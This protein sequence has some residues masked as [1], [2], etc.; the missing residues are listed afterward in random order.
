MSANQAAIAIDARPTVSNPLDVIPNEMPFDVPYGWPISLDRAQ[1]VIQAAVAEAKKREWKMN[2]AVVDS[3]GNLVA[4]QRMDGAM[5]ASIQI[6]EH[7]ARA[8]VTF[9]RPT[10][11]FEDGINLMHLNYLL[12]F[13]GVI[14]SRGGI[15]LIDQGVIIGA[16]GCS[17]GTDSQDEV[18]S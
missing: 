8:A 3:G 6:A 4:F 5:L 12:A 10:K 15:P 16:I 9:R 1:A 14:A 18:V 2:A 17:G 13:D 7:K 11:A